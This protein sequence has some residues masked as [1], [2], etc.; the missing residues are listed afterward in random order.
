VSTNF[1]T[2]TSSISQSKPSARELMLAARRE[3]GLVLGAM[4]ASLARKLS[5]AVSGRRKPS[6]AS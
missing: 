6:A 4:I 3:R 5:L 1:K 2:S